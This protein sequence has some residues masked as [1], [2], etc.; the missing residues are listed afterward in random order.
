[1]SNITN[2]YIIN[3]SYMYWSW[4]WIE[5]IFKIKSEIQS[6]IVKKKEFKDLFG[7]KREEIEKKNYMN[8][9]VGPTL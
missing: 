6:N 2:E 9:N 5:L 1:M 3:M 8:S 7:W 4:T